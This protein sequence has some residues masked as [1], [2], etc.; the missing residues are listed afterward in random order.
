MS[1]KIPNSLLEQELAL[2]SYLDDMLHNAT[3]VKSV[4]EADIETEV[5]I[6]LLPEKLPVELEPVETGVLV[7]SDLQVD[8]TV[9]SDFDGQMLVPEKFPIQCLMFNVGDNLLSIPLIEIQNVVK[10]QNK[11]THL[12]NEP[13]WVLGILKFRDHNVRVV[14]SAEIL[15]VRRESDQNPGYIIVLGDKKWGITCDQVDKVVTVYYD[16]VQWKAHKVNSMMH[17]TIRSSLSSL[18]NPLGII[19]CLQSGRLSGSK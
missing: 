18:L 9:E 5:D 13:D 14:N 16:D 3:Q 19:N 7:S 8:E 6:S 10:W 11:L 2:G 17:G 15:Q 1:E 12:P 4:P